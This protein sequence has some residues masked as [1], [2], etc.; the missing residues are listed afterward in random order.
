[1]VFE[2]ALQCPKSTTETLKWVRVGHGSDRRGG[3]WGVVR[4]RSLAVHIVVTQIADDTPARRRQAPGIHR[5]D[6]PRVVDIA[7][8]LMNK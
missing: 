8:P 2:A 4:V 7:P 6:T 1:M 5:G 3:V